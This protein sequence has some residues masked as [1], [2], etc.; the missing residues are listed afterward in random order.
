LAL[1]RREQQ[2]AA[3]GHAIIPCHTLVGNQT[4]E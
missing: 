2:M 4:D 1:S 3:H